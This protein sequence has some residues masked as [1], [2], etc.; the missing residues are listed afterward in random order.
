MHAPL[1]NEILFDKKS[2][3]GFELLFQHAVHLI[4]TQHLELQTSPENF[5]FI[6]KHPA[7]DDNY[8]VVYA[9]LPYVMLF[10]SHVIM[11]LFNR[12][13][14][15][16]TGAKNAFYTRSMVGYS[17]IEGMGN[18]QVQ[19]ML[20]GILKQNI[21]CERC[22]SS[23]RVTRHNATRIML[24]DSFRC[25]HCRKINVFPFSWLI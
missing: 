11:E 13:Q 9:W 14:Q 22:N 7:D 17:L 12:I 23:L 21:N 19:D 1:L 24:S 16:D 18:Q 3:R 20:D 15:M 6:F 8:H 2:D 5:N 10:L 25:T 4:T